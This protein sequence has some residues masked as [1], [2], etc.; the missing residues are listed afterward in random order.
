MFRESGGTNFVQSTLGAVIADDILQ[1]SAPLEC[2]QCSHSLLDDSAQLFR[3]IAAFRAIQ[4]VGNV[5]ALR[6]LG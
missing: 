1:I 6:R 2:L 4:D 5:V 3:R